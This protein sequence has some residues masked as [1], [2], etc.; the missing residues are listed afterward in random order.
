[1]GIVKSIVALSLVI[2]ATAHAEFK[3]GNALLNDMNGSHGKQMNAL[4]YVSGVA[5]ALMD[6]TFCP[7]SNVTTGQ[8]Y[9]MVKIYLDAYPATRHMTGDSIVNRVLSTAWPCAKRGQPL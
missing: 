5:D 8:I 9:D 4:G 2:C 6:I 1:M 7:P 3:D